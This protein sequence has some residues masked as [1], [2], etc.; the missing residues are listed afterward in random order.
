MWAAFSGLSIIALTAF[1]KKTIGPVTLIFLWFGA[2]LS[3]GKIAVLM[4]GMYTVYVFRKKFVNLLYL[5][6]FFFTLVLMYV[7][8]FEFEM[9]RILEHVTGFSRIIEEEKEGR[10][11]IWAKIIADINWFFGGGPSYIN[12]LDNETNLV[13]ESY[14]LQTWVE[15]SIIFPLTFIYLVARQVYHYRHSLIHI[16]FYGA[17]LGAAISS[18]A[19]SH[20]VFIVIWPLLVNHCNNYGGGKWRH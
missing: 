4:F 15:L 20:P 12:N 10:L 19:F 16:I 6:A 9:P 11:S 18:H 2:F 7:L 8:F 17:V 13:A 3:G 1:R 5:T 14:I